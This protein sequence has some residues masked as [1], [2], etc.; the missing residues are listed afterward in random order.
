MAR[1]GVTYH[2]VAKAAE[3]I[4]NRGE[5][6]TVDRVRQHLGTG[7]KSTIAPLLKRWRSEHE[8]HADVSGLPSELVEGLKALQERVQ[9]MADHKIAEAQQAF[10]NT[11]DGLRKELVNARNA[12]TQFTARQ[13]ELERQ[14][15][16]LTKEKETLSQSLDDSRVSAAKAELQRSTAESRVAELKAEVGELR[17]ENRDI[18]AHFEHYQQ[19]TAEDR[20]QEREQFRA[21]N[22]QLENHL[23][24]VTSQ[25]TQ[26][27]AQITELN[28]N[29]GQLQEK[30]EELNTNNQVLK[31]ELAQQS[32]A[33]RDL[34]RELDITRSQN[35]ELRHEKD[36]LHEK[37]AD[38]ESRASA[39]N[40]ELALLTL[41]LEKSEAERKGAQARMIALI[42]EN[43]I[44]L[45]E[46]ATLE[47]QLKQI[48]RSL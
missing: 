11:S 46:K 29:N 42:D 20:Q 12:I 7:S 3:A 23:Q 45:Q 33:A 39:A 17:Q 47:G 24:V 36:V 15:A 16:H 32:Q 2:D 41:T 37:L 19:R 30:L 22:Q 9:Q 4:K 31:L 40:K 43:K 10:Q 35:Q 13:E 21:A 48:Q 26:R 5:E 14:I 6:P 28:K 8:E 27:D 34:N 25:L 38:L 1:A 18:R 44:L